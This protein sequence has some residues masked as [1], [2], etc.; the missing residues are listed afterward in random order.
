MEFLQ[1]KRYLKILIINIEAF[2]TD[3]GAKFCNRFVLAHDTFMAIDESTTIK[4]PQ[5]RRSKNVLKVGTLAKVKRIATGSPVT[6]SPL[7]LY[8]QCAFLGYDCL[9]FSSYYA[10]QARYA[11]TIERNLATHSFK[12]IIG[13]Q[14]IDELDR[15][16]VV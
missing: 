14:R 12:Q 8:Q 16:S 3:K 1:T 10:F 15:K 4:S 7:D 2:S 5:A 9:G 11:R 13:Y 6:K